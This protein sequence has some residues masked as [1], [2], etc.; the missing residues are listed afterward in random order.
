MGLLLVGRGDGGEG[1]EGSLQS[2]QLDVVVDGSERL[3]WAGE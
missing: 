1:R 2:H 3:V